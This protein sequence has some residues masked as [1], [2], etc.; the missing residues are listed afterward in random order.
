MNYQEFD[1]PLWAL[2]SRILFKDSFD[3][4][5][6]ESDKSIAPSMSAFIKNRLMIRY[7]EASFEALIQ[8]L[9]ENEDLNNSLRIKYIKLKSGD[10]HAQNRKSL[11]KRIVEVLRQPAEM[12]TA[13][14]VYGLTYYEGQ[15]LF[16]PLESND[17]KWRNHSNRPHSYSNSLKGHL[18]KVLIN[19]AGQGD[20]SKKLIDPLCGAGTVLLEGAYLGYFIEGA[21]I[22]EKMTKSALDNLS[23][24]GYEVH[25]K[26]RAIE[27]IEKHYDGAIIDLP[28]GLYSQTTTEKQKGIIRQA[29]R[30][31]DR[32]VIVSSEDIELMID[33]VGLEIIDRCKVLKTKN[34][35][36]ARYVWVCE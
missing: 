27:E 22:N 33:S 29:K 2:D 14:L 17:G 16:G 8:L 10:P 12:E 24:F 9:K 36:F 20:L 32:V 21:D 35:S 34:K 26:T 7:R 1:E 4:K 25:V 11:Y 31:A 6:F 5:I 3:S 15:W 23:H 19:A 28:Y 13:S 18:A 30:I